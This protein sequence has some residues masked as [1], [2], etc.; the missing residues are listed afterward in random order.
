[1]IKIIRAKDSAAVKKLL[2]R[3]EEGYAAAAEAVKVIIAN[4]RREGDAALLE[5][6]RQFDGAELNSGQLK[7]TKNEIDAAYADTPKSVI[8]AI[9]EAANNIRLF[10]EKQK[11]DSW[12][13]CKDGMALGQVVRPLSSVGI[14]VPGGTAAYPSSVLMNAIPAKVAGVKKII[15]VT[16]PGKDGAISSQCLVAAAEAGVDE[17]YK[18]GGA[19]AVAALAYGTETIPAV[20]KITGPGNIYVAAAKREVFGKV[21][22]D[23]IAGPS[24]IV[25]IA[26]ASAR[27]DWL[28]A[29]MLSQAEHDVMAA[30]VLITNNEK[31]AEDTARELEKQLSLLDR[32]DIAAQSIKD[33]GAIIITADIES[34]ASLANEIAPEHLEL[35]VEA[36]F[37]LM[38]SVTD[39]GAIFLGQYAPEAL[40]D[41]YAGPNHVL[42]T[43]GT[44]R[45]SS[46]LGVEDFMKKSSII[47]YDRDELKKA[48]DSIAALAEAE[49]LQ[50]H[51][52]SVLIRFEED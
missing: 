17:I 13:N 48:S 41:Y 28:A 52:R 12:L 44:A 45:F 29:D 43:G 11:Q 20:D 49:G 10:H 42:P 33:Y 26:D 31:L 3:N 8:A 35:A 46:A 18:A 14:Y 4:I 22:I 25:I 27:P 6:T 37:A 32:R 30:A 1:M 5:Y 40:G 51:A 9:K 36:P 24:E 38:K 15:M 47:Y 2:T 21:G 7:V 19:Q 34:A 16:P 39:A 50:A 23:M